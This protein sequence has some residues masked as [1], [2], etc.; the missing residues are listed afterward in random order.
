MIMHSTPIIQSRN[1]NRRK[2][3]KAWGQNLVE[4]A[5]TLPFIV[6]LIFFICELSRAWWTYNTAK[7]AANDAVHTAAMYQSAATGQTRLNTLLSN[8]GMNVQTATVTQMLGQH[9][10]SVTVTVLYVPAAFAGFA[11][12]TLTG[13][14]KVVPDQF[15]I[16]YTALQEAS[17]Y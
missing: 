5:L 15:P 4:L 11:I 2:R 16:N 10:Y 8:A 7:M 13:P 1:G 14:I 9:A 12:P 3:C 6:L 17:V